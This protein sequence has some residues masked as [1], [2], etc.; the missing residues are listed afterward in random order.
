MRRGSIVRFRSA[1]WTV[2]DIGYGPNGRTFDVRLIKPN[3]DG[4]FSGMI[5]SAASVEVV[6]ELPRFATDQKV[7]LYPGG[8]GTV[9][10]DDG[11]DVIRVASE[12]IHNLGG[13]HSPRVVCAGE[14]DV[15]RHQM[16]LHN[17][18]R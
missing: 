8:T 9:L 6:E 3:D 1:E 11:D 18:L 15:S 10:S 12:R 17:M 2:S 14:G 13:M 7:K 4:T 5:T 16:V